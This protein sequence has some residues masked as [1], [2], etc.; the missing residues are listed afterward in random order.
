MTDA[1]PKL[2]DVPGELDA[3]PLL[4]DFNDQTSCE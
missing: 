3:L 2:L 1:D 4:A